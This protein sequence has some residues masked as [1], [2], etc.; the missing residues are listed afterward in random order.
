L[1]E[2]GGAAANLEEKEFRR[3][4]ELLIHFSFENHSHS[5]FILES[6]VTVRDQSGSGNGMP[7]Y[8]DHL[9]RFWNE[10]SLTS[11][12]TFGYHHFRARQVKILFM[13]L[14]TA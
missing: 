3:W 14:V 8:G 9:K 6:H 11:T 7:V 4:S 1:P 13:G 2:E 5:S 10:K 12:M